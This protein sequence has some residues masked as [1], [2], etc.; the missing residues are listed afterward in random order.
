MKIKFQ[1]RTDK[2][3]DAFCAVV[4]TLRGGAIGDQAKSICD[5]GELED[6]DRMVLQYTAEV[7]KE[8]LCVFDSKSLSL[9]LE[10]YLRN[11]ISPARDLAR[12]N[13]RRVVEPLA[14][15]GR[16]GHRADASQ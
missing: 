3:K 16:S 10:Y 1:F 8:F 5:G 6:H 2:H 14:Y 11:S 9:E 13:S 15:S 7:A 4:Y 12:S